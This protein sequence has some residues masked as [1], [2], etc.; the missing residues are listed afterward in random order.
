MGTPLHKKS[1]ESLRVEILAVPSFWARALQQHLICTHPDFSRR[2]SWVR[3][4]VSCCGG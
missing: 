2:I 4:A 1:V 3:I